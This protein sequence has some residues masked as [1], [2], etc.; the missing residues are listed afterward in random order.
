M[1]EENSQ[2]KQIKKLYVKITDTKKEEEKKV[3]EAKVS[4]L[5]ESVMESEEKALYFL[6]SLQSLSSND[7]DFKL[8]ILSKLSPH[9][10]FIDELEQQY[11]EKLLEGMLGHIEKIVEMEE[12][13]ESSESIN[14]ECSE[15]FD[16]V[17]D[18]VFN[19]KTHL[20]DIAKDLLRGEEANAVSPQKAQSM[21]NWLNNITLTFLSVQ[22]MTL[23]E[24][25]LVSGHMF[26]LPVVCTTKDKKVVS[27]SINTIQHEVE[28]QLV[29]RGVVDEGELH[30]HSYNFVGGDLDNYNYVNTD[31]RM[32]NAFLEYIKDEELNYE[33]IAI[34]REKK[35]VH[36]GDHAIVMY[37]FNLMVKCNSEDEEQLLLDEK[38]K[39]LRYALAD[40]EMWR[41]VSRKISDDN[42]NVHI[43]EGIEIVEAVNYVLTLKSIAQLRVLIEKL[44]DEN[45][46]IYV[47]KKDGFGY[48]VLF[49]NKEN[50]MCSLTA[51]CN[52]YAFEKEW[53]E[54]LQIA[55]KD[56][57]TYLYKYKYPMSAEKFNKIA[58]AELIDMNN[59][60]TK[61]LMN[62]TV[63]G[64]EWESWMGTRRYNSSKTIH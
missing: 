54:Q 12:A 1:K 53:L 8:Y 3:L 36:D 38:E 51:Q 46:I 21:F 5:V 13:G 35:M 39:R 52:V 2:L 19:G 24:K 61:V 16:Y 22:N 14:N 15:T 34:S 28:K 25:E 56:S 55:C 9:E 33:E 17:K 11:D 26:F 49:A 64:S 41:D 59:D 63:V 48:Y 4:H 18:L 50:G 44:N 6:N 60:L 31:T 58:N 32:H 7:E 29:A 40:K 30:L 42:T 47:N 20:L 62:S 45:D 23:D 27:P 10:E 43:V 37:P 57:G